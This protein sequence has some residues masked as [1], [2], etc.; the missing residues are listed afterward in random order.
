MPN[1]PASGG[2]SLTILGAGFGAAGGASDV[3]AVEPHTPNPKPQTLHPKPYT[4]NPKPQALNPNPYTL[5]PKPYAL[6]PRP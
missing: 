3:V 4:L 2:V 5:I 1:G 6:N